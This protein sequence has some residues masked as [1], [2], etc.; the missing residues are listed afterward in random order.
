MLVSKS[1]N[2]QHVH[3]PLGRHSKRHKKEAPC[4]VAGSGRLTY[5]GRIV[6]GGGSQQGYLTDPFAEWLGFG[7]GCD[8]EVHEPEAFERNGDKSTGK[9]S[10]SPRFEA[11][12]RESRVV[13][14]I[15]SSRHEVRPRATRASFVSKGVF[16]AKGGGGEESNKEQEATERDPVASPKEAEAEGYREKSVTRRRSCVIQR[17]PPRRN[18]RSTEWIISSFEAVARIARKDAPQARSTG[19]EKKRQAYQHSATCIGTRMHMRL[20]FD[21]GSRLLRKLWQRHLVGSRR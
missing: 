1:Q 10:S 8:N 17:S 12:P 7:P 5:N 13:S 15:I 18:G 2:E 21:A 16:P 11:R 9:P 19:A 3:L 6:S 20:P 14:L 4:G